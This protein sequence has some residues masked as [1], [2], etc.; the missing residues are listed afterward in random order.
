MYL[1]TLLR[2]PIRLLIYPVAFF[3]VVASRQL[4]FDAA[5]PHWFD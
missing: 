5:F 3:L 1:Y 4:P 2:A